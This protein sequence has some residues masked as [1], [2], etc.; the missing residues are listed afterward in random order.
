M[1][2]E[3]EPR[4][5]WAKKSIYEQMKRTEKTNQEFRGFQNL[6]YHLV[7]I[8]FATL[9]STLASTSLVLKVSQDLIVDNS[10]YVQH[11]A[12]I[13]LN[14]MTMCVHRCDQISEG[15][16]NLR[17]YTTDK[18]TCECYHAT[19]DFR[20]SRKVAPKTSGSVLLVDRWFIYNF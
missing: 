17:K 10:I 16:S 15:R 5:I 14:K 11:I 18:Q 3:P 20:D 4:S 13:R 6:I 2:S 19:S 8:I 12:T 9:N 7:F 1:T